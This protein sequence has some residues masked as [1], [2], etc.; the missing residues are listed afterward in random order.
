LGAALGADDRGADTSGKRASTGWSAP[1]PRCRYSGLGL[2]DAA[3]T[4]LPF[5][6]QDCTCAG[7]LPAQHPPDDTIFVSQ[8]E[9]R[10]RFAQ[11]LRMT[12]PRRKKS[13]TL[14]TEA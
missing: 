5:V 3:L 12:Q 6:K 8:S 4:V 10:E 13:M 2:D 7:K 11:P 9:Y 1:P 14:A